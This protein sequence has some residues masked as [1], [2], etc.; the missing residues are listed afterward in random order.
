MIQYIID[1]HSD[2]NGNISN[3]DD[4]YDYAGHDDDAYRDHTCCRWDQR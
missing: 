4:L 3:N 2:E 1:I